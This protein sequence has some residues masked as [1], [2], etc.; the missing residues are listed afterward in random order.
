MQNSLYDEKEFEV[1]SAP[2]EKYQGL[3]KFAKVIGLT[4]WAAGSLV[5]G[6]AVGHVI[7]VYAHSAH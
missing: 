7:V 4:C 2:V 5:L 6:L 1:Y 3:W